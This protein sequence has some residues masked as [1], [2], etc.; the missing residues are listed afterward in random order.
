MSISFFSRPR[1]FYT[2][3][4]DSLFIRRFRTFFVEPLIYSIVKARPSDPLEFA[5]EW[6]KDYADKKRR[7]ESSDSDSDED[8]ADEV[9]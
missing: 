8:N 9:A 7:E 3:F 2:V 5:I 4:S 1:Q 6:L